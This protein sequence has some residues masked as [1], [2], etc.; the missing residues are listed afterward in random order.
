MS[1]TPGPYAPTVTQWV[2]T[3]F[4][5]DSK[6]NKAPTFSPRSIRA[7][8]ERPPGGSASVKAGSV[9]TNDSITTDR[10]VYLTPDITVGAEDEFTLSDGL[11]Y[12]VQGIPGFYRSPFTG[13]SFSHVNLRRIT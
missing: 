7:L 11:R 1:P 10:V 4:T 13:T 3:G 2:K 9:E 8:S 5:T 12:R 6:N